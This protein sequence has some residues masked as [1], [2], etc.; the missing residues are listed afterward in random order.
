MRKYDPA[1]THDKLDIY[2]YKTDK[3]HRYTAHCALCG[4]PRDNFL[5]TFGKS[6]VT[7]Y[8]DWKYRIRFEKCKMKEKED[9]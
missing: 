2:N 7:W 5:H 9:E 3:T 4:R 1:C 6:K 8:K